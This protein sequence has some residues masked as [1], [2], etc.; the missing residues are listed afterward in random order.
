[1][2][3]TVKVIERIRTYNCCESE[4]DGEDNCCEH[5]CEGESYLKMLQRCVK[6]TCGCCKD[7]C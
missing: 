1:M 4:C 2:I 6:V 5:E 7:G 3:V